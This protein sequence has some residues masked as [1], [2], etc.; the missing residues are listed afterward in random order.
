MKVL[1]SSFPQRLSFPSND[2]L[3]RI[4]AV[5]LALQ[6]VVF[7][8]ITQAHDE[9]LLVLIVW[10]G[11]YLALDHAC[12]DDRLRP[13]PSGMSVGA[14]L[15]LWVLWRSFLINGANLGAPL[16]PFLAGLG[17]ALLAAAPQQLRRFLP[18]LA[19]LALLPLMRA[20]QIPYPIQLTYATAHL[21]KF[22]LILCGLP[23]AVQG[24]LVSLPGGS[25][26]VASQCT[27][28]PAMVQLMTIA[29]IFAVV[30]P[31]RWRWQN[32][33]MILCAVS[34]AF[35]I[36]GVRIALLAIINSSDFPGKAW[37]FENFHNGW[38]AWIFPAIAAFFFVNIYTF[39][40]EAQVESLEQS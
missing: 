19:I 14:L 4:L 37:W 6:S 24:N 25:V 33:L 21:T 29:I 36:N 39:W 27:G 1:P 3:I 17:L 11:A 35:L 20:L 26:T 10:W 22:F 38:P 15:V 31:M 30:F 9:T 8:G 12:L 13:T 5:L 2:A 23:V 34:L 40:L 28:L 16:L 32:L 18:S 7:N